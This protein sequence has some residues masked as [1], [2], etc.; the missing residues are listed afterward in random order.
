MAALT[1]K[2]NFLQSRKQQSE[3][4]IAYKKKHVI[5]WFLERQNTE[6]VRKLEHLL[7][8]EKAIR[9]CRDRLFGDLRTLIRVITNTI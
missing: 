5:G 6:R 7:R 9:N 4:N 8:T 2:L 3:N 1:T